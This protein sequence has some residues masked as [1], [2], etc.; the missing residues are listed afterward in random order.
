[1]IGDV[2]IAARG[3]GLVDVTDLAGPVTRAVVDPGVVQHDL[4]DDLIELDGA[5]PQFVGAPGGTPHDDRSG[6]VDRGRGRVRAR[7]HGR[8]RARGRP[9]SQEGETGTG[10]STGAEQRPAAEHGARRLDLARSFSAD[11]SAHLLRP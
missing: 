7:G 6:R 1:M 2:A 10:G 11:V 9:P 5:A 3:F 4:L 8:G